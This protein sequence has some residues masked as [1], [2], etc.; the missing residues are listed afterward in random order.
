LSARSTLG[1]SFALV[2]GMVRPDLRDLCRLI[3]PQAPEVHPGRRPRARQLM[4]DRPPSL[5]PAPVV[6]LKPGRGQ[7]TKPGVAQPGL[8][9]THN[10]GCFPI[11]GVR[12][13]G[14][15]S[16][17]GGRDRPPPA[18]RTL[19]PLPGRPGQAAG[20]ERVWR[21]TA[22][23]RPGRPAGGPRWRVERGGGCV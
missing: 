3:P 19:L 15:T 17:R 10:Q 22:T 6:V 4:N 9:H 1:D 12:H 13:M 11:K 5:L 16:R 23:R 7:C 14:T 8:T 21:A 20:G 18:A 2:L